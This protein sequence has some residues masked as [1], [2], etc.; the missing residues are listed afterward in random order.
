MNDVRLAARQLLKSPGFTAVALLSLALGIGANTAIFSLV[1]DFLLRSL[2]VR[3]PDELVL[4]RTIEG[5]RGR[6][7][8]AGE[9]NG[10]IDPATG[11]FAST[12]FSL[13]TFERLRAQH[14]ALS[15]VFAFASFSQVNVL[16]DGQPEINASAQLV[17]GNYHAGLGV[18]AVLGRTLRPTTIGPRRRRSRS[19]RSAI[20]SGASAA[21]RVLGQDDPDQQGPGGHRRRDPAGL[22]RC[23]AGWRI[24]GRLG[25]ARPLP[26]LST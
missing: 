6:M 18:P 7:S 14:S 2:P 22:R 16:V 11:R 4:L 3:N 9:N 1:N 19:S 12:S 15:D 17:S 26:A 24:G 5:A 13:L 8:R 21:P 10:F 23:D 20:G 25:A